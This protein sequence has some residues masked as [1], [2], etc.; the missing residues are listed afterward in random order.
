[1]AGRKCTICDHPKRKEIDK[2]LVTPGVILRGIARQFAV[3]DD[4]LSRHIKKGHIEEKV[5]KSA[6]AHEIAEADDLLKEIRTIQN[7]QKEIFTESRNRTIKIKKKGEEE[8]EVSAP[9]N[10]LALEALRDQSK[11]IELKGKILGAFK[12]RPPT[13][14][15]A[16]GFIE[17]RQANRDED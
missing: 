3:S 4:A 17:I 16:L 2:A 1:M 8:K 14:P 15:T 13:P 6:R 12:E 11:V 10:K 9:D 7:H 5:T